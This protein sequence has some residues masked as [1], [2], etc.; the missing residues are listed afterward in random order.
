MLF[1]IMKAKAI[2]YSIMILNS[3]CYL[4]MKTHATVDNENECYCQFHNVSGHYC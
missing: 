3:I 2:V 1:L 4:I